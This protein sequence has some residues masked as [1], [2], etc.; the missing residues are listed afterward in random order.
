[1]HCLL[2]FLVSGFAMRNRGERERE[3]EILMR[4]REAHAWTACVYAYT[5]CS[6]HVH[7][8]YYSAPPIG[9]WFRA[10]ESWR[11][12]ER[13]RKREIANVIG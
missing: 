5:H 2:Q 11:E 4:E 3:R 6:L 8:V 12:N 13:E 10:A 7:V 1:M 9:I